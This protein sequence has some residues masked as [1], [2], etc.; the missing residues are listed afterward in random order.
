LSG[1]PL[2]SRGRI[3]DF[4][5]IHHTMVWS[6][7]KDLWA[8]AWPLARRQHDVIARWQL[9]ALGITRRAIEHKLA[10]GEL[11]VLYQGVYAVRRSPLTQEGRWIA[12]VLACGQG[13]ALSHESAAALWQI[14]PLARVIHVSAPCDRRRTGVVVHRRALGAAKVTRRY[15]IPVSGLVCTL[16]DIAAGATPHELEGAVSEADRLGLI[17]HETLRE[18]LNQHRGSHGLPKLRTTLDRRTYVMTDTELERLFLPI[19]R[20]A[21]L[22]L[23]LTQVYVNGFRVDFYWPDLGLVVETDGLTTHRTPAQQAADRVRDQLHAASGL[24]PLRFTRAQVKFEPAHVEEVLRAV[25]A[26]LR[27]SGPGRGRG[28]AFGA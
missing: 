22:P 20:R 5:C 2:A 13:A 10:K 23:P 19:A 17:D 3:L 21:G 25:V 26:R 24:V 8:K 4:F 11:R 28:V 14:W 1:R 16:V 9:L 15:N 7:S 6:I 27:A 18:E 12:A